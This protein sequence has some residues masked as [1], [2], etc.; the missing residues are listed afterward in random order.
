[1]ADGS[2]D[3]RR[4]RLRATLTGPFDVFGRHWNLARELSRRDVL[5]RYRGASFGML[6]TLIG[7]LMMLGIYSLAFGHIFK[8][9]WTQASGDNAEF[10]IVLF[11][12]II[13]HGFFAECLSRAPRLMIENTNFVKR[14]IF[15]LHVLP[16]S[17]VFSGLF[18]MAMNMIVFILLSAVVYGKFS[19]LVFLVPIVV[20]P[21]VLLTIST[22]WLVSSL[23]VYVRDINQ[24]TPVVVTALFFLSSA[25]VPVDTLPEKYQLIFHLNPLTFFIDQVRNVALWNRPPDWS[26]LALYS[27]GGIIAMYLSY[28]WFR[29]T[30]KG[31][32]DVL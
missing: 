16:W 26:G 32:A 29:I 5:G 30:S 3:G 2:G 24:A 18:H 22:M 19:F 21:L 14:I 25:I 23:G 4:G 15:P 10:A 12:G 9:R 8:S 11:L 6:W 7:P 13:V 17:V 28:A 31:F 20:A 1:M 27:V